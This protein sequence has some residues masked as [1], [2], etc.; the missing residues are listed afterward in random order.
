[1][2]SLAA[3]L[4][5]IGSAHGATHYVNLNNSTP[6]SPYTTWSTAALAIQD[7]VN[8]ASP[9]D[10]VMV[11]NG[12]YQ[13]GGVSIEGST[14]NRVA[15]TNAVAV[16]SV[17]GP[18]FTLIAGYEVPGTTNGLD[19]IRCAY[20]SGGAT[21]SGFTLTNGATLDLNSGD[22][23][24]GGGVNCDSASDI[25][26]N[27]VIAGNFSAEDG[28]GIYGGTITHCWVTNNWTLKGGGGG[29]HGSVLDDCVVAGNLALYGGGCDT[30][31]LSNCTVVGNTAL[32]GHDSGSGS[33]GGTVNSSGFGTI[34]Y[35]NEDQGVAPNIG[36]GGF[37]AFCCSPTL[38]DEG[39]MNITNAPLFVNLA[40]NDFHI[41]TNSPCINSGANVCAPPGPD[42]GGNPR[43]AGGK[44]DIGAY[45]VQNPTSVIS[46]AWL[47]A[48]GL[49]INGSADFADSD[50]DG[51]NNYDEW[52][53]GTDPHNASSLL[54]MY[55][56]VVGVSG[57]NIVS[58]QGVSGRLYFVQRS[59]NLAGGHPFAT[60]ASDV[61]GQAGINSYPDA[62]MP[63]SN[64][65]FYRVWTDPERFIIP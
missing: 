30:C 5:V 10:Q 23:N 43:I 2:G 17:N 11:T 34:V 48:N 31:T 8:V 20:L 56:P 61:V 26:S 51:M 39:Y 28:G 14:T 4:V 54:K 55:A 64:P 33:G 25:V 22:D 62:P 18:A 47:E 50:G 60:V 13:T 37:Y 49:P 58:W 21:L 63:G 1:M 24:S 6:V 46:F 42:L 19:A 15:I 52:L 41:A 44:A 9:G 38:P 45:E 36:F 7:A 53:A 27:C 32:P 29:A 40:A 65:V 57:T 35:Y 3:A 12:V 59:V 16:R